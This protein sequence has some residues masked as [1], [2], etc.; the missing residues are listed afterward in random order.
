MRRFEQ[1]REKIFANMSPRDI[2]ALKLGA[3][4]A[5]AILL[6]VG[7]TEWVGYWRGIRSSL[8]E[9]KSQV[10]LLSPDQAKR[11]GMRSIVPVFEFPQ[12][13]AVQKYVFRDKVNEQLKEAQIKS[14]PLELMGPRK[15]KLTDSYDVLLIR[16]SGE[17]KFGGAL[18]LLATMKANPY[19]LSVEELHIK[20][21]EKDPQKVELEI[22]A[23]SLV[24]KDKKKNKG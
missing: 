22:A 20:C 16:C 4:A 2:R 19:L 8:A 15:S 5:A 6:F 12:P 18:D 13:E 11:Q 1:I 23:S 3:A 10:E 9:A 21:D 7:V 14:K 24:K 17:G